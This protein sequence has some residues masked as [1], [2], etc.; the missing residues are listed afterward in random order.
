MQQFRLAD[1]SCSLK[2]TFTRM[3]IARYFS[4]FIGT[5]YLIFF[6]KL[7]AG[8]TAT[9]AEFAIGFCLM[10]LVYKY[11]YISGGHYNPA[12]TIGVLAR[13]GVASF[14]VTDVGQII[15]YFSCQLLGGLLGGIVAYFVGGEE[16]C[17]VYTHVMTNNFNYWQG[18]F[19]EFIGT[20]FLATTVLHVGTH[21]VGNEFYGLAIGCS[22]LICAISISKITGCAINPAVWFGTVISSG[23]CST[24]DAKGYEIWMY[25]GAEIL[26]GLFA[27]YTFRRLYIALDQSEALVVQ[28]QKLD[29]RAARN[30]ANSVAL[31]NTFGSSDSI[32]NN[33]A[34]ITVNNDNNN[35]YN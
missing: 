25:W 10:V 1:C 8:L 5:F 30:A 16:T 35:D 2:K 24:T 19:A 26:A 9:H 31:Q 27:G 28:K 7:S 20:L 18:F 29:D 3:K 34:N 11:G 17:S 4:E 12:V 22:L 14:P 15:M 13:G 6:I 33:T 32:P 23:L 21:Q